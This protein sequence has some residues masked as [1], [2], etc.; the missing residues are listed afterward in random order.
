MKPILLTLFLLPLLTINCHVAREKRSLPYIDNYQAVS[1]IEHYKQWG[2]YNVHDPSC[3][4]FGDF[5]YVYS[6]DAIYGNPT[7]EALKSGIKIGN[8]Q[9]RRSKDLV[10]WEFLGWAFDSIPQIA[11]RH[12]RENNKGEGATNIWAPFIFKYK[13]TY[14]MYYCVSAFGK[15]TSYIGL[16]E[17]LTP[18][19]P[20][21]LKGGVLKTTQNDP[22]NAIDPSIIS[23]PKNGEQWMH[24]GSY[25]DGLYCVQLNPETGLTLKSDDKGISTARRFNIA[26]NNIEPPEIIYNPV[27]KMYYLF[28][29]YDPLMTTYNIRVGRSTKPEG[30]FY[31][32]FGN[33]LRENTDNYPVLTYPYKFDHHPGWAG[34][35]H[36]GIVDDG[37]G[38]YFVLHQGR[39]SPE[40]LMMVMHVREIFWTKEGWPV[41]SP[42]R[43]A[44]V[45]NREVK[46]SDIEGK[47]EII[48]LKESTYKRGTEAGQILWGENRL[49]SEEVS[50]SA[51]YNLL[52]D[53]RIEY[54]A[55]GNWNLKQDRIMSLEINGFKVNDLIIH[56][57]FDWENAR[58]TLLFTGLDS[59]GYSIW[60][61]KII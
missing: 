19:G 61:K 2:V 5:Y 34:T 27:Q 57:G 40:N 32:Y 21:I 11:V 9:I 38:K 16:A 56:W 51:T 50:L 3:K 13:S 41:F 37:K 55:N 54:S 48:H 44:N 23:N 8:I 28:V 10:N 30:P 31:D 15:N 24:Y 22:M 35:G 26:K 4:K 1:G 43:Y 47:W 20:W 14:R 59:N 60:G 58:E 12:V 29:S 17:S 42:E 52:K 25:F 18:V 6:T 45:S 36:C 39:L 49:A 53:G 33:D 7:P 46:E